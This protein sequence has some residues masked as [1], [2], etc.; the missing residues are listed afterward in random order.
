MSQPFITDQGFFDRTSAD[1]LQRQISLFADGALNNLLLDA[2]PA[3]LMILNSHQQVVYANKSLLKMVSVSDESQVHGWRPGE[4][5]DCNFVRKSS[6]GCGTGDACRSCGALLAALSG[7]AGQ[8][9]HAE[10]CITRTREGFHIEALDLRVQTTPLTIAGENFTVFALNDISHEKRRRVLERIFFH[11]ILNVAGSIRGFAEFLLHHSPAN[12]EEI[13]SL[14]QAAADQAIEEIETQRL[15]SAA[16]NHELHVRQE[17]VRI[18]DFL[19][20]TVGLYRQ[21]QVARD[22][23]LQLAPGTPDIILSSD[24]TLLRRILGNTIKNALEACSPG[25]TV[26]VACEFVNDRVCFSVHNPGEIPYQV[27]L[28]IFQRSFSTKGPGRGLG[29]YSLRLLSEF[30][31]SEVSFTSSA[32]KGTTFCILHPMTMAAE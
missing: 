14:I 3:P 11:D 29:T 5:L 32:E 12:R 23:I 24:Q 9:S 28:K 15:L 6:E 21:H 8:N 1:D 13:Y 19:E 10:C 4:V 20:T 31:N 17:P 7:L 22:R 16:E 27:R 18:I 30:L 25:D 26:T 2:I